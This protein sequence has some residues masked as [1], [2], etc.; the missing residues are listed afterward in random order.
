MRS[1]LDIS[2]SFMSVGFDWRLEHYLDSVE[3]GSEA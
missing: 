1:G 2:M 3:F